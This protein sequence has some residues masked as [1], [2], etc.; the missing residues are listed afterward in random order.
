MKFRTYLVALTATAATLLTA[1]TT[2]TTTLRCVGALTGHVSSLAARVAGLVLSR[3]GALAGKVTLLAAVVAGLLKWSA[4]VDRGAQFDATH[5][6]SLL[7]AVTGLMALVAACEN[8][9]QIQGLAFEGSSLVKTC[10]MSRRSEAA[11][12]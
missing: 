8:Q 4:E 6:G 5:R 3:L 12:E 9:S 11:A 1:E 7:W 2:T 10:W